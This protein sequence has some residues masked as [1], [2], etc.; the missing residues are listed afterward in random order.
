MTNAANA[1][2]WASSKTD[3]DA[4]AG[5]E[6]FPVAWNGQFPDEA[7]KKAH[8]DRD[9]RTRQVLEDETSDDPLDA[10]NHRTTNLP[11]E[12]PLEE[13]LVR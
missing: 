7:F 13:R 9:D 11:E 1:E 6:C 3:T 5:V 4:E 12:E 10:M 8:A 2:K